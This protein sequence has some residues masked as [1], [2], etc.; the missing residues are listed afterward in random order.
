MALDEAVAAYNSGNY[1]L[2]FSEFESAD[3][4]DKAEAMFYLGLM[5][6]EGRGVL[7]DS[8][9]AAELF[10]QSAQG[11]YG[12]GCNAI[13][14]CYRDG[15]GVE[16]DIEAAIRWFEAGA[17]LNMAACYRNLGYIYK[18]KKQYEKAFSY[19][20]KGADFGNLYCHHGIASLYLN[21]QGV[22]PDGVKALEHYAKAQTKDNNTAY[23]M[24]SV[25]EK[26]GLPDGYDP[27]RIVSYARTAIDNNI[28]TDG[29][30]LLRLGR[31]YQ[32]LKF[33]DLKGLRPV[34][35]KASGVD[36]GYMYVDSVAPVSS[37]QVGDSVHVT[38]GGSQTRSYK[39]TA[40]FI[41]TTP[42]NTRYQISMLNIHVEGF[43][44]GI[45]VC[46]LATSESK[47]SFNIKENDILYFYLPNSNGSAVDADLV[48]YLPTRDLSNEVANKEKRNVHPVIKIITSKKAITLAAIVFVLA[49][50][51]TRSIGSAFTITF[52][53]VFWFVVLL[54]VQRWVMPGKSKRVT[55][56]KV[57][58]VKGELDGVMA[59]AFGSV[60]NVDQYVAP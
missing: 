38:G 60:D 16:K 49:L 32:G 52:G 3:A 43:T 2:A 6:D 30:I 59:Y 27:D 31:I 57:L 40:G 28:I 48:R 24:I 18:D 56:K 5:Y 29:T 9:K 35:G 44:N 11:G 23:G 54:N 41:Y 45:D 13:G 14:I 1:E 10:H 39:R 26:Y 22:Q 46:G 25:L 4:T 47:L 58:S 55:V 36:V 21:G 7:K 53:L 51:I 33:H 19:W 42:T 37:Y 34:V 17:Q 50:I 8:R 15:D 12:R 20:Q